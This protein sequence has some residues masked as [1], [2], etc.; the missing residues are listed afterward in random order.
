M[1][2]TSGRNFT[3]FQQGAGQAPEAPSY[4][5]AECG[6][7]S[8]NRKSFRSAGEDKTCSTGH[9][10]DKDGNLRRAKNPYARGR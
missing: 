1:V 2:T 6:Y 9:Y 5:C 3:A 7:T 8:G 4:C 10:Q